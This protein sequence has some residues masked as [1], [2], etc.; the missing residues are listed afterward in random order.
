VFIRSQIHAAYSSYNAAKLFS[1][2]II[3]IIMRWFDSF[4]AVLVFTVACVKR[5]WNTATRGGTLMVTDMLTDAVELM[6]IGMVTVFIFLSLL[7]LMVQLMTMSVRRFFPTKKVSS[8]TVEVV[9]SD[10][11]SPRI[12]AAITA[13]V[14]QH[15][16]QQH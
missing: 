2:T 1:R 9:E 12:V 3:R 7:V 5:L 10:V 15:R 4:L 6:A 16:Q 13:A 8:S 11:I 14:H